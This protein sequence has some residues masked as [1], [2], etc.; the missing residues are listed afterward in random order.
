MTVNELKAIIKLGYKDRIIITKD[1]ERVE[2]EGTEIVK[3]LQST[4]DWDSY[5]QHEIRI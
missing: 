5:V 2:C 4:G 1:G 3:A